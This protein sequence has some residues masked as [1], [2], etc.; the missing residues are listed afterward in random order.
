MLFRSRLTGAHREPNVGEWVVAPESRTAAMD[1]VRS[2][3]EA[4]GDT[5]LD[6]SQLDDRGRAVLPLLTDIT[7]QRGVALAAAAHDPWAD[8]ALAMA[9]KAGGFAPPDVAGADRNALR[10]LVRRRVLLEREGI[11]WHSTAIDDAALATARLL[12]TAPDGFTMSEFREALGISRKFAV[13]LATELDAR[14]VTRRR[15][16]VRI[17]GPR[18]PAL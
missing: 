13:P 11:Y 7:V 6:V 12:A 17:G 10:E 8:H 14:G 9:A 2:R 4:A 1:A 3:V 18:L 16:D 15:G 5:G